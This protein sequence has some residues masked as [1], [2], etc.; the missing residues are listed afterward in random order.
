[1]KA[2]SPPELHR[3]VLATAVWPIHLAAGIKKIVVSTYQAASGAARRP[4]RSWRISPR[5][6]RRQGDH[7]QRLPH[8]I[9]FNVF[10]HDTKVAETA[11]T[12]RRTR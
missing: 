8:Q 11:T 10:S 5:S 9:A 7:A 4:C 12:R 2:L 3:G 1:M 6:R